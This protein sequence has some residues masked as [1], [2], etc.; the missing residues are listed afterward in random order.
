MPAFDL[1][2]FKV[3][4]YNYNATSKKITYGEAMSMGDAM[5]ANLE[6]KFAEGR[7]YAESALA[8]YMK[9]VTGGTIQQQAKYIPDDTQELL[10]NAYKLKRTVSS[11]QVTSLA[12]GKA[13]TGQYVG[14]VFYA[15]DMIDGTEK[16][17]AIFV[18]KALFAPP[19][20]VYQTLNESITF[21]TPTSVGEFLVDDNGH[22]LEIATCATETDAIAW[23]DAC[24][25]TD[26]TTAT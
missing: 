3:A 8:E 9:K 1:R 5:S 2:G 26:P 23:C 13:S 6:L 17:T 22:L 25:T 20:M 7:L 18:H 15:P 4:K 21:Q 16:F 24:F 11:A 10:F 19:S 14:S 12:F